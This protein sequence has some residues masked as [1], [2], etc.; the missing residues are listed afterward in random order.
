MERGAEILVRDCAGVREGEEVLVVTDAE[1]LPIARAV[2]AAALRAGARATVVVCPPRRID[3]EE[4]P[5]AVAAAM[6]AA[7]VVF[8]PVTL[9]LAH[10][11]ATREAIGAGARVLS[12]SAFT[13][14]QMREGGLMAD[15]R[16]RRPLCDALAGRLSRAGKARVTNPAGTDLAFSLEGREGNSHC[17]ILD[18]P[19]FTAVPN[20]EANTSPREGTA[21]GALVADGSIPYYGIGVLREPVRFEIRGGFVREI[22]G[23]EQAA[24]LRDLLAA[25]NDRWVY[26]VAQF[27][28]GLNPECREFTGE[29]LND[30]GVNGTIHF[31]VGTSANLGGDVQ[32]KTHFDAIIRKPSVWLDGELIIEAGEIRVEAGAPLHQ[33]APPHP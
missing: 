13:E 6:R 25:Q 1:R 29:M 30:E 3:N 27:A 10:T 24:F 9:A 32:A 33:G 16:A 15:F 5:P 2:E 31:G 12:M 21:E 17:C 26:N 19:G 8:L 11:R 23:G 28:M 14:R 20:I 18:G 7:R 22:A 4:P